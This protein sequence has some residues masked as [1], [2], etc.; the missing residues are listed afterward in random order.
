VAQ[1][2]K[3]DAAAITAVK[4]IGPALADSIVAGLREQ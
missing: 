1:L 3:A 2:R 4:G